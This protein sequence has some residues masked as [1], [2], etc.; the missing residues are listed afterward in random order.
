MVKEGIHGKGRD[1]HGKGGKG[2]AL[3]ERRPLQRT[4]LESILV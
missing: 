3:Q 1:V 2:Y 4:V